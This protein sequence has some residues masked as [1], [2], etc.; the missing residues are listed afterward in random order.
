[1]RNRVSQRG[2][3]GAV[4]GI[5]GCPGVPKGSSG[6]VTVGNVRNGVFPRKGLGEPGLGRGDP[7]GS[8]GVGGVPTCVCAPREGFVPM[9]CESPWGIPGGSPTSPT[10]FPLCRVCPPH[11]LESLGGCAPRGGILP[12]QSLHMDTCGNLCAALGGPCDLALRWGTRP[13][14]RMIPACELIHRERVSLCPVCLLGKERVSPCPWVSGSC[15]C[16]PG[17]QVYPWE[18]VSLC[19]HVG[20]EVLQEVVSAQVSKFTSPHTPLHFPV[21]ALDPARS[22]LVEGC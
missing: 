2:A 15:G 20:G 17:T 1:M 12:C 13:A 3:L 19:S 18:G 7:R 4:A 9:A 10:R 11:V 22:C 21:L 5:G 14:V 16:P 6:G 8:C